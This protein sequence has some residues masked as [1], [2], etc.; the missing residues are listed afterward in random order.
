MWEERVQSADL[1]GLAG[2]LGA[3]AGA[4]LSSA[5]LDLDVRESHVEVPVS[6][7]VAADHRLRVGARRTFARLKIARDTRKDRVRVPVVSGARQ[8]VEATPNRI[9]VSAAIHGGR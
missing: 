7:E 9:T 2:E 5:A 3:E 1:P 6:G 4:G 8:R